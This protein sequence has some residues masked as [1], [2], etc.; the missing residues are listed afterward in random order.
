MS[1]GTV[2]LCHLYIIGSVLRIRSKPNLHFSKNFQP[3][4]HEGEE[5]GANS[6]HDAK[7]QKSMT[8][9][10]HIPREDQSKLFKKKE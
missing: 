4:W 7:R 5:T 10:S 9:I 3:I 6:Y 8:D 2:L 1:S